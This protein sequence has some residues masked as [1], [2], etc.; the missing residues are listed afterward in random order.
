L[1]DRTKFEFPRLYTEFA[2]F[3]DRLENQYRDYQ[4]EA[5][6]IATLLRQHRC[7]KIVD[8]SCGTGTHLSMLRERVVD[9]DYTGMDASE[10]MVLLANSKLGKVDLLVADFLQPPFKASS[11]DASICM[12][13]SIAGLNDDLVRRLFSQAYYLTRRDGL[14][15][16]DTENSDGIKEN[17]LNA[18]FIDGFI[19]D[20]EKD[21]FLIRANFSTKTAQDLVDWHSYYLFEK[22]GV[23]ELQTDRMNLRFY[24]RQKLESMLRE[25]GF[26]TVDVMSGPGEEYREASPS[27]YFVAVKD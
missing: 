1:T 26:G 8:I 22:S 23:S 17:L 6:W 20:P 4:K 15:I 14:F 10:Q 3:Y 25:A 11:F 21:L 19:N 7:K 13:W 12:Y 9:R 24:S 27:L 18:P 5:D 16:F 2:K